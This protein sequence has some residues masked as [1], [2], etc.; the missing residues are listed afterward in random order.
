MSDLTKYFIEEN[1][2]LQQID[3]VH[4]Q[5]TREFDNYFKNSGKVEQTCM[6]LALY[7]EHLPKKYGLGIRLRKFKEPIISPISHFEE[8]LKTLEIDLN[9]YIKHDDKEYW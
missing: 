3:K 1:K 5:N 6:H 7:Q 8:Y 4:K 9:K 2:L